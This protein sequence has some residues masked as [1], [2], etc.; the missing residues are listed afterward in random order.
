MRRI[1]FVFSFLLFYN[2]PFEGNARW[3]TLSMIK[4]NASRISL[5][6]VV[7]YIHDTKDNNSLI[8]GILQVI[9]LCYFEIIVSIIVKGMYFTHFR[10]DEKKRQLFIGLKRKCIY[11]KSILYDSVKKVFDDL[12]GAM[13][14][15]SYLLF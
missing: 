3:Q 5:I 2:Y 11:R 14:F 13:L 12:L 7:H 8:E 15:R 1:S 10:F 4:L 6:K 9:N